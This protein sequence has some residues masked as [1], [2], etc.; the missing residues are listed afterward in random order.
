[1]NSMVCPRC[2][3]RAVG[4]VGVDQYYCADCCIEFVQK[5][6]QIR[7]YEVDPEGTLVAMADEQHPL[8]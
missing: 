5:K 4:R 6:N 3:S 8:R 2:H 1:M 7:L